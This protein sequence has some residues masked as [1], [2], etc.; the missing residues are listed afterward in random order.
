MDYFVW[1]TIFLT[2]WAA[3]G[4]LVG[5]RYGQELAKRWQREHWIAEHKRRE[6]GEIL[7]AFLDVGNFLSLHYSKPI[8]QGPHIEIADRLS[9]TVSSRMFI[10]DFIK[11]S[12]ITADY[13]KAIEKLGTTKD[14]DAFL[15]THW[16]I[17][18]KIQAG[19]REIVT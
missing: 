8:L 13:I 9:T 7:S 16:G 14:V 18:E 3:I 2:V 10:S 15:K 12:G 17:V 1:A 11:E 5:I 4:P 19:V 6:F